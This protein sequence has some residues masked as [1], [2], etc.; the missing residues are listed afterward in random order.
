MFTGPEPYK[1]IRALKSA[2]THHM[3]EMR[4]WDRRHLIQSVIER[5]RW[6]VKAKGERLNK[7]VN[8][9]VL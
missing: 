4:R 9:H 6:C 3:N 1:S 2:I 5:W 8:G 7:Y